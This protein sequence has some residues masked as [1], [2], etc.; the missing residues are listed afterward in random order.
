MNVHRQK[1]LELLAV[2]GALS[3]VDS[4][5]G[6][7]GGDGDGGTPAGEGDSH[8]E[9]PDDEGEGEGGDEEPE[10]E[11]EDG[12]DG[13]TPITSKDEFNRILGKRLHR[14]RAKFADYDDLK[15]KVADQDAE[16]A[17]LREKLGEQEL[18]DK[19]KSIADEAGV[20]E[21]LLRGADEAELKAHA[22]ELKAAF[23]SND[24]ADRSAARR[25]ARSPYTGTGDQ[26]PPKP[27]QEKGREQARAFLEKNKRKDQAR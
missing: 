16:L 24:E 4:P 15:Q 1:L 7:S 12:E 10:D 22:E 2:S 23:S 25:A 21:N 3:H 11:D 9:T 14:E 26:R 20:P 18:K 27:S 6:G 19:R 5:E 17:G 8:E 13:F